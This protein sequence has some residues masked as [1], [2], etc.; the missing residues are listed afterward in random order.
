M[1]LFE[2]SP[3]S[4]DVDR[5]IWVI[6]GDLPTAYVASD[7]C[8]TPATALDGYIGEMEEWVDAVESQ[9]PVDDLIPVNTAATPENA[10]Q[11]KKRLV[12]LRQHILVLYQEDLRCD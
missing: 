9:R 4:S 6:V 3:A 8:L 5:W 12:F 7:D 10:V 2:I 11:L 1:F